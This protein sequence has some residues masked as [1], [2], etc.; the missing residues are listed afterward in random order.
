MQY[1]VKFEHLLC[2]KGMSDAL[3]N[4]HFK[5]YEGYVTNFNKLNDVGRDGKRRK[6]GTPN[7]QV[8]R[9]QLG[10][11]GMRLHELFLEI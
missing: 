2:T 8:N 1:E 10:M 11:N 3:L 4:N 7:F 5:L 6:F 9:R